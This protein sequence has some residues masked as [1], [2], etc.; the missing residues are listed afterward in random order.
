MAFWLATSLGLAADPL[1]V[2]PDDALG[3]AVINNLADT[4]SR[5]LKLTEKMQLPVPELLPM[6]QLYTGAQ[7]GLDDKGSLAAALF[8][9]QDETSSWS[10]MGAVFVPVSD[11]KAFVEQLMPEDA[12]AEICTV[13]IFGMQFLCTQKGDFAVLATSDA[14]PL[15]E[16]IKA[17]TKS[18]AQAL[19]PMQPWIAQQQL[20]VVATPEGKKKL[21]KAFSG[22]MDTAVEGVKQVQAADQDNDD[23]AER[24]AQSL[25]SVTET[26]KIAKELAA[27]VD[28]QVTQLGLGIR[29]DDT[30]AFHLDARLMFLPNGGLSKW[31]AGV[32][33][34]EGGLLLGLP[35][36]KFTLA[37]GGAAIQSAD[38]ITKLYDRMTQSGMMVLGLDKE[39]QQKLSDVLNKYRQN[40]IST[41]ALMGRPRPGDSIMSTMMQLEHVKDAARQFEL[42]REMFTVFSKVRFPGAAD[43]RP[44]YAIAEVDVGDLKTIEVTMDM[45]AM[46]ANQGDAAPAVGNFLQMIF[47]NEGVMKSYITVGNDKTLVMAYSKEQ[48]KYAVEHVRSKKSGLETDESIA[49]TDKLLPGDPQWAAYI[50]PQGAVAWADTI[51]KKIP[52][53]N[54]NLPPFP[55]SDPIGLAAKV[56]GEGLDADLVLPDSVVAGIG[57]YIGVVQQMLMG[58][59]APL[60]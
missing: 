50:S 9:A 13:T 17:S 8:P 45:G 15:V 11:Y 49:H 16:K 46:M 32:K 2:I 21:V 25:E 24:V 10:S 39:N 51:L 29:I 12:D 23:E 27:L 44:A 4:S 55:D 37:Y 20:A 59:D 53:L 22:L 56:T 14:R 26:M 41:A 7:Q 36:G 3:V 19:A 5:I 38:A 58:G 30:T 40:Q 34:P 48:L 35:G 43:D 60:P 18:V 52:D 1:T 6:A 42:A 31:A 54:I 57:Q 28:E 33:R 47:G